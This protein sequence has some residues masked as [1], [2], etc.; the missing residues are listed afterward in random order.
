MIETILTVLVVGIS[1]VCFVS[2][3]AVGYVWFLFNYQ[4]QA[5][6]KERELKS[7][8]GEGN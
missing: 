8:H 4:V 5:A 3:I 7:Q 1:V 2:T 6:R